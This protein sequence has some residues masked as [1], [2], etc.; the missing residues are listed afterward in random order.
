MYVGWPLFFWATPEMT[1]GHLVFA[2]V[3]TVYILL[4]IPLEERALVAV[5]GER[6]REYRA[7]TPALLPSLRAGRRVVER[8][9]P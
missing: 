5:F 1:V 2:G 6:Y 8:S 4:A 7:C 3:T 9:T